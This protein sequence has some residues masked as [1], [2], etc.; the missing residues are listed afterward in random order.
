MESEHGGHE[1]HFPNYL[2]IWFI[3]LVLTGSSIVATL[4][5]TNFAGHIHAMHFVLLAFLFLLGT[6]KAA[7][8][9]ANFMHLRF[10]AK[11]LWVL[12]LM[13]LFFVGFFIAGTFFDLTLTLKR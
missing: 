11:Y 9:V 5:V 3:L 6:I 8:V 1:E 4:L 7:L 2:F 13:A 12:G 10:E